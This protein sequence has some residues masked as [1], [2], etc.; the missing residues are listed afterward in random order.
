MKLSTRE[1]GIRGEEY[2]CDRLAQRGYEILDRNVRQKFA[3]LDIVARDGD[4]MCF[5]EVRT[6]NDAALGHPAETVTAAKQQK[7]RRAAEAYIVKNRIPPMPM[8]FDVATIIW[9]TMEFEYFENAFC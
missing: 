6:R 2:V 9:S 3:E 5:V 1:A 8:R 4:T 7:I